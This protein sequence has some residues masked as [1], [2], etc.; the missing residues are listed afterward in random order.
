MWSSDEFHKK[1]INKKYL[2]SGNNYSPLKISNLNNEIAVLRKLNENQFAFKN[3]EKYI[4]QDIPL[5]YQG[6]NALIFNTRVDK[7]VISFNIN[8]PS[9][10]YIAFLAH[11]PYPLNDGFENTVLKMT[12]LQLDNN[13]IV[14]NAV[15]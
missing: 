11:Y 4:I 6:K 2:Y 1:I 9:I 15:I 8:T 13:K 7:N 3:S 12:L 5:L 14:T 10:N